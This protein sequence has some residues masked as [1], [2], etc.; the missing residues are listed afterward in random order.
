[1]A[2]IELLARSTVSSFCALNPSPGAQLMWSNEMIADI[3]PN[4]QLYT[5]KLILKVLTTALGQTPLIE[6]NRSAKLG[7]NQI[8]QIYVCVDKMASPS[9]HAQLPS[10]ISAEQLSTFHLSETLLQD[11][12]LDWLAQ[13]LQHITL[14]CLQLEFHSIHGNPYLQT[15]Y[16]FNLPSG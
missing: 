5:S 4:G 14:V 15:F 11:H 13:Q 3:L 16:K 6:C 2:K 12:Q 7:Y 1:L 9:S 10:P 8:Y